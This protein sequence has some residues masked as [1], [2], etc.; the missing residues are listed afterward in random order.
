MSFP[1][2]AHR[3]LIIGVSGFAGGFLAEHLLDAG[4]AVLGIAPDGR[5]MASSPPSLGRAVELVSWD[6][7]RPEGPEPSVVRRIEQFRPD[8]IYHLAAMSVPADCGEVTPT[9]VAVEVNVEGTRRVLELAAALPGCPRVL[10]TSSSYVYAP[11]AS[12]SPRVAEDAAVGPRCG[13]GKTK[14]A[15]EEL[16]QRMRKEMGVDVVI[17]RAFQHAG[18]RQ[19][20]RMMLSQWA[21][22]YAVVGKPVEIYTRDAHV[23]VTDVRDVVRAYR[24]LIERGRSGEVYNVGSSHGRR[25]GDLLELLRGIADPGRP[26]VELRPGPKQDPIADIARLTADTG[27]QPEI[28]IE[29]TVADTWEYWRR[30]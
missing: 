18:P 12:S 4:D 13:Y 21:S 29:R 20:P 11:V 1:P 10:F 19:S 26:V 25:T 9:P 6:I 2:M 28:S 5:W 14:L 23:D 8:A 24:L 22:Q 7:G 16:A 30:G 27:W 15:A 17:A 3:A